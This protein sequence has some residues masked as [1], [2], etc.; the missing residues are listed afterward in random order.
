MRLGLT[1]LL[2]TLPALAR[3]ATPTVA[4]LAFRDLSGTQKNVGEAIRETVTA[5]L[6]S[7]GGVRVVERSELDRVLG[8]QHL[9]EKGE[10]DAA[11][12]VRVGKLLGATL[13]ATGAYQRAEPTV[14]VTARFVSVE[15][16]EVVGTAKVDGRATDMLRLQDRVT[17]E[18]LRSAG[19]MQHAHKLDERAPHRP[20]IKSWKTLELYGDAVV[21]DNDDKKA[22]LLKLAIAEDAS[23]TYAATDLAALEKRMKT[24]QERASAAQDKRARELMAELAAEKDPQKV[25]VLASTMMGTL[26]SARRYHTLERVARQVA[27]SPMGKTQMAMSTLRTDEL[28]LFYVFE[29]EMSLKARDAAL[30]DGEAFLQK[31]PASMYFSSVKTQM[32]LIIREKRT[33]EEGRQKAAD[34][35]ARMRSE[36]RWDLCLVASRYSSNSQWA[37]A[38]RLF[39]ACFAVGGK[40]HTYYH[41]LIMCDVNLGDFAGA[42]KDLQTAEKEDADLYR[43]LQS[44]ENWL[45]TDG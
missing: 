8:E 29:A 19:L 7:L 25:P 15:T 11:T 20:T 31:F 28:A 4:V 2:L 38:Q 9:A 23:F 43:Q 36:D 5:D 21:A 42:R 45:P 13:I 17:A 12:A 1:L 44:Y 26:M 37:E 39:R 22:E 33:I 27:E 16:G 6:K 41:S 14:R 24:Y 35:L 30:R 3:A 10:V 34:E 18:L 40:E 32:D